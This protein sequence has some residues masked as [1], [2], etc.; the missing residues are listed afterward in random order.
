MAPFLSDPR[1][2]AII[3]RLAREYVQYGH[4]TLRLVE[5]TARFRV[6]WH[7]RLEAGLVAHL[8]AEPTA[9][10]QQVLDRWREEAPGDTVGVVRGVPV[11]PRGGSRDEA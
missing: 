4:T 10:V 2:E 1:P 8:G 7:S 3:D 11:Y 6:L 9:D 5:K